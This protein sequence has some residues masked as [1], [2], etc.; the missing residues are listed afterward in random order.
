LASRPP[1]LFYLLRYCNLH[2]TTILDSSGSA[3]W[4]RMPGGT[5]LHL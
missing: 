3:L 1:Y 5:N 4:K 2:L